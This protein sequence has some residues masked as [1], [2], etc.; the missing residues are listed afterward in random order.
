[1]ICKALKLSAIA[2]SAA[3]VIGCVSTQDLDAVRSIAEQAQADASS[4]QATA[5]NALATAEEARAI[6]NQALSASQA[7]DERLNRMFK[8]SMLK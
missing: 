8:R 4:A 3:T 6:A 2:L 7:T 5:S 1:M